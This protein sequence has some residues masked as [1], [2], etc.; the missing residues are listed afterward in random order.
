MRRLTLELPQREITLG[1]FS[2]EENAMTSATIVESRRGAQFEHTFLRFFR[3]W[4]KRL[5]LSTVSFA[6]LKGG[7]V[8]SAIKAVCGVV[9]GAIVMYFFQQPFEQQPPNSVFK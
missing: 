8:N 6:D 7:I 1:L 9:A 4:R 3:R 5:G 2:L